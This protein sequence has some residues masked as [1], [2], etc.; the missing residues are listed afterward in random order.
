MRC[1]EEGRKIQVV[2]IEA[3]PVSFLEDRHFA[4][5][6][7]RP[8][9]R[10]L[11]VVVA[12]ASLKAADSREDL[13]E[14]LARSAESRV[15][16]RGVVVTPDRDPVVPVATLEL[17]VAG[18]VASARA[19]AVEE[20]A[21]VQEVEPGAAADHVVSELAVEAV[22]TIAAVDDVVAV[23]TE[24]RVES[25]AAEEFVLG[26]RAWS[27]RRDPVVPVAGL[28]TA[29]APCVDLDRIVAAAGA[30]LH[31]EVPGETRLPH[32]DHLV[33]VISVGNDA[34]DAHVGDQR[35]SQGAA[36]AGYHL[37]SARGVPGD[38]DE[39]AVSGNAVSVVGP[40]DRLDIDAVVPGHLD[41]QYARGEARREGRR[42]PVLQRFGAE[43][44]GRVA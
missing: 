44:A 16:S 38:P 9:V 4:V 8:N 25:G 12:R 19:R 18:A 29:L 40:R 36:A 35:V 26:T 15:V 17:V 11:I 27:Q 34:K 6:E 10:E 33:Q 13:K 22:G 39:V 21:L 2:L 41:D 5:F 3:D 37:K 7:N 31:I 32:G 1:L 43:V 28:D 20:Q 24:D 42:D 23:T 14:I 30:H